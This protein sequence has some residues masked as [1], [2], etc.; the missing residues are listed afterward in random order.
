[1]LTNAVA[2]GLLGAAYLTVLVLQLNPHVPIASS[3]TLDWARTLAAF[4]GAHLLVFFYVILVL[5]ELVG[6]PVSP[7][8]VSVR[9]LA[10]M[11][12][13]MSGGA[14]ALMWINVRGFAHTIGEPAARHMTTG[15]VVVTAASLVV[16]MTA[17][18]R[19]SV[20]RKGSR[21][22]AVI[23]ALAVVA[24]IAGPLVAR[25]PAGPPASDRREADV[26]ADVAAT[27]SGRV[28][29]I[30]LDGASLE[31]LWPRAARGRFP[32]FD[33]LLGRGATIDLATIRP[34]QPEPVWTAAATGKYPAASGVRSRAALTV[35]PANVPV[36]LLP[37]YAFSHL[38]VHFGLVS[39][40]PTTSAAVRAPR[41]WDILG[42]FRLASGIVRWPVTSPT[43]PMRGFLVSDRFHLISSPI[44]RL[45]DEAV[46]YPPE[47]LPDA[48]SIFADAVERPDVVPAALV[49]AEV[50]EG[51][52]TEARWDSVYAHAAR[53]LTAN[54]GTGASGE[55]KAG[56]L[57]LVAIRY[58][59]LDDVGHIYLRYAEPRSF[60]DVTEGEREKYGDV[61]DRYYRYVDSEIGAAVSALGPEDL[62]M[63]VSGFGLQPVGPAKRL[64]A[65]FMREG[66]VTGT[67]DR[68]PDGFL[69]AYGAHAA[70]G[71]LQRG[72]IVD[73]AP[74]I[75]YYL[76]LPVGRDMD[77]FART[78]L[79][80]PSFTADRP[81]TFIATYD[82]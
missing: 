74:T 24:S 47:I 82:R 21:A 34:T 60:G 16:V 49:G 57:T 3:T 15:A 44:L 37:D 17:M 38:L 54:R 67:H 39:S 81:I 14:A 26:P 22:A 4:Y 80:R 52:D 9:L 40:E 6:D 23:L 28:F 43:R 64:L 8:W 25:G 1:M 76:G 48:R 62:L 29:L 63:V 36:D 30:L 78:D 69:I 75:L 42:R 7:G 46:A 32:N 53:E 66:H 61:L 35:R 45:D 2:G 71:K 79:F 11:T 77:G 55:G 41:L 50:P 18:A 12:A 73:V 72:S 20:G 13:L 70:T 51:R 59:G 56:P 33:R 58:T 31:Y 68:A 65:R 5:R 19:Y 27:A 10:W